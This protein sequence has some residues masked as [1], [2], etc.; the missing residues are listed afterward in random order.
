MLSQKLAQEEP[1]PNDVPIEPSG[2]PSIH[3]DIVGAVFGMEWLGA[4]EVIVSPLNVERRSGARMES[5][6]WCCEASCRCA[7]LR[8]AVAN[9]LVTPT[10][11]LRICTRAASEPP[12]APSTFGYGAGS[13]DSLD[14]S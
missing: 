9:E 10:G 8:G 5:F 3:I 11:G 12:T 6:P 14:S 13:R 2:V 4:D 7:D 1:T